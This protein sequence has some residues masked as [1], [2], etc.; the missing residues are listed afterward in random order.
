MCWIIQRLWGFPTPFRIND[1]DLPWLWIVFWIVIIVSRMIKVM[2]YL[3]LIHTYCCK[4]DVRSFRLVFLGKRFIVMDKFDTC[5]IERLIKVN[6]NWSLLRINKSFEWSTYKF[7]NTIIQS[8]IWKRF[9]FQEWLHTSFFKLVEEVCDEELKAIFFNI[10]S[11]WYSSRVFMQM[12]TWFLHKN[13][14]WK[15]SHT[16][17]F[18]P[19][20]ALISHRW[21]YTVLYCIDSKSMSLP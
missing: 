4:F 2:S 5:I 6:D 1:L 7:V 8:P 9:T 18:I 19:N 14:L 13:K 21:L 17:R 3:I 12:F 20:S 11:L 15:S 10:I 16:S